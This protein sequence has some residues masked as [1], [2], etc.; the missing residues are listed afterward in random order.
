MLDK[1]SLPAVECAESSTLKDVIASL[2][3]VTVSSATAGND[4]L[5]FRTP[6]RAP[7]TPEV[8]LSW[9]SDVRPLCQI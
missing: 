8:D 2:K 7:V 1:V 4:V 9:I 6:F 3:P 5:V